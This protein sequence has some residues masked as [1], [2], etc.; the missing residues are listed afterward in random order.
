[1]KIKAS[2][3]STLA[4]TYLAVCAKA[5]TE[6]IS[7]PDLGTFGGYTDGNTADTF[8]GNGFLGLDPAL[9]N[10]YGPS[11]PAFVHLFGLEY[12]GGI[13]SETELQA[14]LAG[15]SGATITSATLNFTLI[16]HNGRESVGV[17]SFSTTGALGYH[18]SAPNNLGSLTAS[19]IIGGAN[20]IN[21][22]TLVQAAVRA[23]Q[24]ELGLF[25]TPEGPG[26]NYLYTYTSAEYGGNAG[27]ADAS[28][29]INYTATVPDGGMTL[30]M[31]GLAIGGLAV[32]RRKV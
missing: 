9:A 30:A 21:V 7:L 24:S 31:L 3:V 4:A 11:G 23:D 2:L 13:Y 25:L 1:M 29:V 12:Y 5:A 32:L 28:L 20:S 18:A 16:G 26:L 10:D 8:S 14:S 6:T 19:G 17:T 22:T 27:S 15:L